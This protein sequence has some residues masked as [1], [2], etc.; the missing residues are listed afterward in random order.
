MIARP[1]RCNHHSRTQTGGVAVEFALGVTIFM[2][3]FMSILEGGRA[4]MS[5]GT[6][7]HLAREGT[8]YAMVRGTTDPSITASAS[9]VSDHVES[10][11]NG[12]GDISVS[13]T[14]PT[15]GSKAPG[16]MVRVSVSTNY[17]SIVPVFGGFVLS[18]TSEMVITY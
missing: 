14:W 6:L 3:I 10:R 12:V 16:S 9:D 5:Y 8:R 2:L 11:A 18:S 13:T 1:G 4:I 15:G 17:Q 7:A